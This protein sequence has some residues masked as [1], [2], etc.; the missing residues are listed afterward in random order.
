LL[1]EVNGLGETYNGL[2]VVEPQN[3]QWR[4]NDSL[5][6]MRLKEKTV[7]AKV[8]PGVLRDFI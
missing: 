5:W 6:R 8:W 1:G 7:C 3:R 4:V 2:R